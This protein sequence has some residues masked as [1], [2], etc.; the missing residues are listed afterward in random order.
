MKKGVSVC[1]DAVEIP[2]VVASDRDDHSAEAAA[3]EVN[4][5]APMLRFLRCINSN[6]AKA[7]RF[8]GELSISCNVDRQR[9]HNIAEAET[10]KRVDGW[11]RSSAMAA[12]A[13]LGAFH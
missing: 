8:F 4:K 2:N 12:L 5:S 7:D 6:T 9:L 10:A 13:E 1:S 3:I 11:S